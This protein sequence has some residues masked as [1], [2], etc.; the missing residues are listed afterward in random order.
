MFKSLYYF[1]G[2]DKVT[3]EI[4]VDFFSTKYRT[5]RKVILK[6]NS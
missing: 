5:V 4:V 1:R 2:I 6:N 3:E